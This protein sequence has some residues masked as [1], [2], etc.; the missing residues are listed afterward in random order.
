MRC[1]ALLLALF[2]GCLTTGCVPEGPRR[3]TAWYSEKSEEGWNGRRYYDNEKVLSEEFD[4]QNNDGR[5]DL[6]RF[7]DN[8]RLLSEERDRN[9]DGRIDYTAS[10]NPV[11]GEMRAFARDSNF[12]GVNDVQMEYLGGFRWNLTI[13]R[14]FDKTTDFV[15]LCKGAGRMLS[16]IGA[17][18]ANQSDIASLLPKLV[19]YEL[20]LDEDFDGKLESRT[21]FHN[22]VPFETGIDLDNDG[23]PDKWQRIPP[24]AVVAPREPE[25]E[26]KKEQ[27]RSNE[28]HEEPITVTPTPPS[29]LPAETTHVPEPVLEAR[30]KARVVKEAPA[31]V[32]PYPEMETPGGSTAGV[33]PRIRHKPVE[34]KASEREPATT[35]TPSWYR[36]E[37]K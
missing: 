35:D 29:P 33:F 7:Y 14:D 26:V 15:L 9:A 36:T 31:A 25:P 19:W 34:K 30:P 6:W 20:S 11:T 32:K 13:D 17:D 3:L 37:E 12:D 28:I 16:E 8:G 24:V 4:S 21:R 27:S 18:Y 10:W 5:I 2:L 22:G 1:S 23:E